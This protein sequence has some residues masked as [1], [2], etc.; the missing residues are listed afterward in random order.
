MKNVMKTYIQHFF[1]IALAISINTSFSACSKKEEAQNNT[2]QSSTEST[3]NLVSVPVRRDSTTYLYDGTVG[4]KLR[5]NAQFAITNGAL[6]GTYRY[7]TGSRSLSLRGSVQ[8]DNTVQITERDD[9][10]RGGWEKDS[11][12]TISGRLLGK[13]DPEKGIITG[14]WTSKDGKK[15]FPFTMRAV[16]PFTMLKH[17]KL[18]VSVHYPVFAAPELAALKD[19]LTQLSE[20][21]YQSSVASIDTMRKEYAKEETVEERLDRLSEHSAATVV[22]AASNLVS[23]LWMHDSYGGGAHGIYGYEGMTWKLENGAPKRC[24][25][26]DIFRTDTDF[27]AKISNILVADLKKQQASLVV[28]SGIS[29]FVDDLLKENLT[30]TVHPSGITFHFDPYAVASYAEGPFEVHIAWKMLQDYLR[31]D[32]PLPLAK[33]M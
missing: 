20:K 31:S 24:K 16:A 13:L 10:G 14:T 7:H 8:A 28:D 29:S 27:R 2:K 12:A 32:F 30:F 6:E 19:T 1:V 4:D 9:L 5:V 22:Y 23:L 25:L 33:K 18:D 3:E 26:T 21:N 15:S 17:S 11:N